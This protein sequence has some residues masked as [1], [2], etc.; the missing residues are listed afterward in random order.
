MKEYIGSVYFLVTQL[1][2]IVSWQRVGVSLKG[3]LVCHGYHRCCINRVKIEDCTY[4]CYGM[5]RWLV[6]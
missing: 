5:W 2:Q 6:T 4:T 1:F 3:F